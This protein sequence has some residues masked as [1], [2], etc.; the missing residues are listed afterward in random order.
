MVQASTEVT[1]DQRDLDC[2][3][4]MRKYVCGKEEK[5]NTLPMGKGGGSPR[6]PGVA[7]FPAPLFL[8]FD[9]IR[10]QLLNHS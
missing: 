9:T 3:L 4:N 1:D 5:S 2:C 8:H 6:G 7:E 10:F